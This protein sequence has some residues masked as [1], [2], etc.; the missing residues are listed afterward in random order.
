M[1]L[2]ADLREYLNNMGSSLNTGIEK[3]E[4]TQERQ[5]RSLSEAIK[6]MERVKADTE[7]FKNNVEA[8]FRGVAEML[9]QKMLQMQSSATCADDASLR[10]VSTRASTN[11]QDINSEGRASKRSRQDSVGPAPIGQNEGDDK[12]AHLLGLEWEFF[13]YKLHSA[14]KEL[15]NVTMPSKVKDSDYKIRRRSTD[16]RVSIHFVCREHC[17]IFVNRFKETG[18]KT[19]INLEGESFEVKVRHD[20]P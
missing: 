17:I 13:G 16:N 11:F 5:E 9:E 3:L 7:M 12:V 2:S 19:R 18:G 8:Q 1:A 6:I 10:S 20:L 14:V 15:I 4:A